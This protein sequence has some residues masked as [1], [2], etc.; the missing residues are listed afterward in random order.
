M[1][2]SATQCL[3]W[4]FSKGLPAQQDSTFTRM[5]HPIWQKTASC[6]AIG[7]H[8]SI[9]QF[10]GEMVDQ[11]QWYVGLSPLPVRVTTRIITFLVGNP[12]KPS[13]P[14]LL[15]GGT[16]QMICDDRDHQGMCKM[17]ETEWWPPVPKIDVREMSRK[18]YSPKCTGSMTKKQKTCW[19]PASFWGSL[20]FWNG[21]L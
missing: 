7:L 10:F 12:Y 6:K 11:W 17:I 15:G 20:K 16:T 8:V 18:S 9:S 21:S 1:F 13:F 4:Y 19:C 3:V 14:L 2:S 5:I